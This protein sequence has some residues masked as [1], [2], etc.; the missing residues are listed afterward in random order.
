MKAG[1]LASW[2]LIQQEDLEVAIWKE[3]END[4]LPI[5][6]DDIQLHKVWQGRRGANVNHVCKCP[7]CGN[8]IVA[9]PSIKIRKVEGGRGSNNQVGSAA[10]KPKNGGTR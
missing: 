4:Y 2:L 8:L 9:E 1:E 3:K 10:A 7:H 5:D 6:W